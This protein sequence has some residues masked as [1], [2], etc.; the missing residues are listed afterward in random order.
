MTSPSPDRET[1]T[2]RWKAYSA[3]YAAFFDRHPVTHAIYTFCL[4]FT[5]W[6]VFQFFFSPWRSLER[7]LVLSA[8]YA[9]VVTVVA[10]IVRHR[11]ARKRRAESHRDAQSVI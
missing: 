9:V 11:A 2:S 4:L 1:W 7:C 8:F 6:C 10:V 5:F 3:E